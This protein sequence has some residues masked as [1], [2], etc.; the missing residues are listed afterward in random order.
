MLELMSLLAC[1][2]PFS[3]EA[4]NRL[5]PNT[6]GSSI[7]QASLHWMA[8]RKSN[9]GLVCGAIYNELGPS[10]TTKLLC[11]WIPTKYTWHHVLIRISLGYSSLLS[12]CC[13]S[14]LLFAFV[15]V[16]W[17]F[18]SHEKDMW[19]LTIQIVIPAAAYEFTQ[20]Y[21]YYEASKH[22]PLFTFGKHLTRLSTVENIFD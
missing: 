15:Q 17:A 1:I 6:L 9:D 13:L 12:L 21:Y 10:L 16:I 20:I 5:F 19:G 14:W 11:S 3:F 18:Q 4:L 2:Y 8:T 22:A 7:Y